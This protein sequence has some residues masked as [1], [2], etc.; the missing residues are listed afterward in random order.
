MG[1]ERSVEGKCYW[2]PLG[3]VSECEVV[4]FKL[5]VASDGS[6]IFIFYC[7]SQGDILDIDY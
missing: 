4:H 1:N 6:F 5:C 2:K 3:T 7:K